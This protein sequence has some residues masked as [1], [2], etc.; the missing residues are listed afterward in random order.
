MFNFLL[1]VT[2]YS[3]SSSPACLDDLLSCS[4]IIGSIARNRA[5]AHRNGYSA[6][7]GSDLHVSLLYGP[8]LCL[9]GN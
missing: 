8:G 6:P 3:A 4:D 5:E 1:V 2:P 7:L 9:S